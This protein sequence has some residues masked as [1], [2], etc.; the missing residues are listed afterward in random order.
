MPGSAGAGSR[1]SNLARIVRAPWAPGLVLGILCVGAFAAGLRGGF[2]LDDTYAIVRHPVVQGTAPWLDAF[3]LSFWGESLGS[4]PPSYRPI[5]TLSFVLDHRLFGGSAVAFHI[6]S[7]LYYLALVLVA[8]TFAK[9]CLPPWAACLAMAFFAVMPTH[10]ENVSSLVGRADTLAVL[11]SVL[12]LLALSP[13]TV[14]GRVTSMRRV[15]LAMLAFAAGL[16]CKESIAVLPIIV[17]LFAEYRRRGAKAPSSRIRLHAPTA[18][19]FVVLVAYLALRLKIQPGALSYT[20]PTD[21]L[22]G[23]GVWQKVAYGVELLARYGRLVAVPVGLCTGRTFAEVSRPTGVSATLLLGVALLGIAGY[24]SS[25]AYRR[26]GFPF[27]AAALLA[28]VLVTGVIFAMPESMAD[29]FLILPSLFVCLA[30][31]PWLFAAWNRATW[32]RALLL[33]ALGVQVVLSNAQAATWSDE[34]H[35][36]AHAVRACPD[37]IHNHFRYAEYLSQHGDVDEAVWHYAVFTSGRHAFPYAWNHPAA[38]EEVTVPV[39]QRLREMHSLLRFGLD[40][41]TWRARFAAYLRSFGRGR[42]ARRVAGSER[43]GTP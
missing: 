36:L 24:A 28:W 43:Q 15:L 31:G 30:L 35:L 4:I 29:R 3:R 42:E 34:G 2:V 23:A 21:V 6:S 37:S 10:V 27:V 9:R 14:D 38:K 41:A 32:A 5:A 26:G 12:A 25:T 18:A 16:L 22:V 17:G 1:V 39:D 33:G 13:T 7:L 20:A 11:F 8:W 40:E 19:L